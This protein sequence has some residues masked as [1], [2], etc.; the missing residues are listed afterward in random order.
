MFLGTNIHFVGKH[1]YLVTLF[2]YKNWKNVHSCYSP[3][4][5]TQL[6]ISPRARISHRR[7]LEYNHL[8]F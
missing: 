8:I 5:T 4:Y 7:T 3:S 2:D 6:Q 1:K